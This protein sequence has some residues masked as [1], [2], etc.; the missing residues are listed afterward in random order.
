MRKLRYRSLI[1]LALLLALLTACLGKPTPTPTPTIPPPPPPTAT[2]LPPTPRPTRTPTQEPAHRIAV[3]RVEAGGAGEFYDTLTG[4]RFVPRGANYI[5][6]IVLDRT[7]SYASGVLMPGRFDAQRVRADFQ[8]LAGLEYNTVRLLFD[9]CGSGPDCIGL[10]GGSGLNPAYLDNLVEVMRIARDEGI[11]LLLA[12]SYAPLEGGYWPRFEQEFSGAEQ[13]GF[14]TPQSN[15]YF[16]HLGGVA[17]QARYWGDLLLA[18][19]ERGAPLD[20][21]LGWE[22]KEEYFLYAQRPPLAGYSGQVTT[23]NGMIYNVDLAERWQEMIVESTQ[24][25]VE[26]LAG[27]IKQRDSQA[28][29]S[30][31]LTPP[32]APNGYE[33]QGRYGLSLSMLGAAPLDFVDFQVQIDGELTLQQAAENFGALDEDTRPVILGASGLSKEVAPSVY[34]AQTLAANWLAEACTLGVD[35]WLQWT[36]D[37]Q[38]D[39]LQPPFWSLLDENERLLQALAPAAWSSCNPPDLAE[40]NAALGKEA[41]AFSET[42]YGPPELAVDGG[43]R[44]W[45]ADGLPPQW[46][47]VDL[48]EAI[49]A[50]RVGLTVGSGLPGEGQTQVWLHLV[51]GR[52]VLV[53]T[54]LGYLYSGELLEVNLPT[55]L[56]EVRAVRVNSLSGWFPPA[57]SEIEVITA[58]QAGEPCL[59]SAPRNTNLY[60]A[61]DSG[62][63]VAA[64]LYQG[65]NPALADGQLLAPDGSQWWRLPPGVWISAGE[66][67][68]SPGCA[69]VPAVTYQPPVATVPVTFRLQ[70]PLD[71]LAKI[72]LLGDF[73]TT[74][75]PT[76]KPDGILMIKEGSGRWKI[77]LDLPPGVTLRY[78]YGRG[79]WE[80]LERGPAC[81]PAPERSFQILP[82]STGETIEDV[83]VMWAGEG[84][85]K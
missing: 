53:G 48:K 15:A 8:R 6:F 21:I 41:Y 31:G 16:L 73:A 19:V 35:G 45:Q 59:L 14:D 72:Y 29:V 51:G 12:S 49:T 2:R 65:L 66:V 30:V 78:Q 81:A 79:A 24:Y 85:C 61:P 40:R 27:V 44:G 9:R 43:M 50:G 77:T 70:A 42:Y 62:S 83:V 38:P 4:D 71:P 54:F 5:D 34:S 33:S 37:A 11:Y 69:A 64:L 13:A 10:Q 23:A 36:Y 67:S 39:G 46:I 7:G 55:P 76:W 84:A 47:E 25:W 22:L 63:P 75:Y 32:A 68:A 58:P 82:G 52:S 57:W 20:V 18:L 26:T 56:S 60:T 1:N 74:A 3:R 28:L 80:T 17:M